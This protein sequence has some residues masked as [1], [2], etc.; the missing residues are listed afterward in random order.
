[1]HAGCKVAGHAI[2]QATLFTHLSCQARYKA[3]ATQNVIAHQQ[4]EESWVITFVTGLA[5]QHLGLGGV[6]RNIFLHGLRQRCH[7]SHRR[8]GGHAG[9]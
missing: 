8:L 6:K 5:H 7:L 1:M 4:G 9:T 3:A 2:S